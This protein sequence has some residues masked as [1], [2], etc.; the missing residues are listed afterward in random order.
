[1]GA[2][3]SLIAKATPEQQEEINTE[4]ERLKGEGIEEAEIETKMKEKYSALLEAIGESVELTYGMKD[5]LGWKLQFCCM[6]SF[7]TSSTTD[8]LSACAADA[9]IQIAEEPKAASFSVFG[10][11]SAPSEGNSPPP[12]EL[13]ENRIFWEAQFEDKVRKSPLHI[14]YL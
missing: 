4:Y 8:A 11:P 3:A 5:N 7:L 6:I 1:M 13:T 10:T 14:F 2:S 12:A 9:E